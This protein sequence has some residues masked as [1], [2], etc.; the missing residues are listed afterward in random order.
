MRTNQ[1]LGGLYLVV[2]SILPDAKLFLATSEALAGGVDMLQF[3]PGQGTLDGMAIA[4][5]LAT[6]AKKNSTPFLINGDLKTAKVIEADGIHFDTYE[7]APDEVR[8][9]L[10][11]EQIIGYTISN[12]TERILWADQAGADYVSFCSVFSP[13]TA[14]QC[15]IVSLET[16]R[17]MKSKTSLTIF[18]AGGI[19]LENAHVVLEA[20]VDG[21]A[22]T[23]AL[24]KAK[25][26][27]Q[28]AAAFKEIIRSYRPNFS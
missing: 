1:K 13:R 25:D 19:S 6:L 26:P 5:R 8:R 24:L 11:K 28:T 12:D 18:A 21:I 16:I 14:T 3:V 9:M 2:S 4:K 17:A 15:P 22:V 27:R 7:K 23:S 10:G 20:G